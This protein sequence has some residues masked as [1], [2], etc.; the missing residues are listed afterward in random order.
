MFLIHQ[1]VPQI[2]SFYLRYM[3]FHRSKDF[4]AMKAGKSAIWPKS[5]PKLNS[6]SKSP[7][8]GLPYNDFAFNWPI[9]IKSKVII[10]KSRGGRFGAGIEFR[11]WTCIN[12]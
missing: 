2:I 12:N 1:N 6:C 3:T 5:S 9:Y 4:E 10:G 11:A 7:T 8:A